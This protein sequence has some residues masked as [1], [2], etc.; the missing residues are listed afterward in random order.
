[1]AKHPMPT[2]SARIA[3]AIRS[4]GDAPPVRAIVFAGA[5]SQA[6]PA[7][8]EIAPMYQSHP[9]PEMLPSCTATRG[10]RLAIDGSAAT[11]PMIPMA[12]EQ[13]RT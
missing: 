3:M 11:S 10:P 12:E 4:V 7:N 9:P 13:L 6:A 1:M 2:T 8:T 5:K